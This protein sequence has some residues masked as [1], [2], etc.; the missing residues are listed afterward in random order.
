MPKPITIEQAP[1]AFARIAKAVR[2]GAMNVFGVAVVVTGDGLI[3]G[4]PVDE[5]TARSNWVGTLGV[6]NQ[7]R[8]GAYAPGT[9]LGRTERANAAGA[10]DQI[11]GALSIRRPGQPFFITNVVDYIEDLAAGK[12]K[13]SAAGF[14]RRAVNAGVAAAEKAAPGLIEAELKKL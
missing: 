3:E 11:R 6:P 1:V 4:T 14:D 9:R 13:Q 10:K 12:S 7:T 2:R 8:I 5:G